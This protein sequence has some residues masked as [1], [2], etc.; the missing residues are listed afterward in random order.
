VI[1]EGPDNQQ[2]YIAVTK[3]G[4]EQSYLTYTYTRDG[5]PL[6]VKLPD[7]PGE[8][9]LTYKLNADNTTLARI[10]ITVK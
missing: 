4:D 2:D 3:R 6:I 8:Y 10:P 7:E 5:S 9:D 1:W